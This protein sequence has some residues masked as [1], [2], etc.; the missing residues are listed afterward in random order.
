VVVPDYPRACRDPLSLFFTP[1][2][3]RPVIDSR[4]DELNQAAIGPDVI[5]RFLS[6][7]Q[8]ELRKW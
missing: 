8:V 5:V 7:A 6:L 4:S 2:P 1:D 3:F